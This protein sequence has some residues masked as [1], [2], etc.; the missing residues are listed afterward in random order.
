[1]LPPSRKIV[2]WLRLGISIILLLVLLS[3]VDLAESWRIVSEANATL[4]VACFGL[5]LGLRFLISLPVVRPSQG[6]KQSRHV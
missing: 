2:G 5:F 6:K 3:F 4:V 1:M